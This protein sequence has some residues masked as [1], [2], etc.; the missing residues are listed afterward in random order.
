MVGQ[1]AA[2]LQGMLFLR[3]LGASVFALAADIGLFLLLLGAGLLAPAASAVSYC[4]GIGAH[5]LVSS[6]LVFAAGA[7]PGGSDRWRQKFLFLISAF[8]G[9]ALTVAIVAGGEAAGVDPRLAKLVAVGVSFVAT[10]IL[11]KTIVFA[12]R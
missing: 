10:Y 4:V 8:V 3:Y 1:I 12:V 11:R 7:A 5:W 6:R 9:L 2:R